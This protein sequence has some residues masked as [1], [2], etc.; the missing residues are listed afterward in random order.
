MLWNKSGK[1]WQAKDCEKGDQREIVKCH[2]FI[3][4]SYFYSLIRETSLK[5]RVGHIMLLLRTFLCPRHL[6]GQRHVWQRVQG[7]HS[8]ALPMLRASS[9]SASSLPITVIL[10]F[11]AF[12]CARCFLVSGPLLM[13]PLCLCTPSRPHSALAQSSPALGVLCRLASFQL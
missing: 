9:L 6:Q 7:L 10:H 8:L 4:F 5:L 2:L 12:S 13:V 11:C 1:R 3:N